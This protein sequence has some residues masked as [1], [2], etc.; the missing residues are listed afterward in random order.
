M[1]RLILWYQIKHHLLQ[2]TRSEW[3]LMFFCVI[4]AITFWVFR[5]LAREY[6]T[7]IEWPVKFSYNQARLTPVGPLPEEVTFSFKGTGWDLMK[8]EFGLQQRELVFEVGDKPIK[9]QVMPNQWNRLAKKDLKDGAMV[10]AI[11]TP[12][13]VEFTWLGKKKIALKSYFE[14]LEASP[15]SVWIEGPQNRLFE[16]ETDLIVPLKAN[17]TAIELKSDWLPSGFRFSEG[18]RLIS[19]ES[20]KAS[21]DEA[22]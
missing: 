3:G 4:L 6:Q 9:G 20:G 16:V 13:L 18:P 2:K 7:N 17:Q 8:Q 22:P 15:D 19:F 12:V 21:P 10:S 1:L 5:A 11:G 14:G